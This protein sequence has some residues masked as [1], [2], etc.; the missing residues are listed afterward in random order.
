M[1]GLDRKNVDA[2]AIPVPGDEKAAPEPDT[3]SLDALLAS[4]NGSA[5]QF[6]TLWFSFLGLTLYF[7]IAALTATHQDLLLGEPKTL[8]AP[9]HSN[10]AASVLRDRAT[11]LFNLSLLPIDDAGAA[12]AHRARVRQAVADDHTG[13]NGARAQ[14]SL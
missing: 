7:A 14:F 4:L 13:R 3:K 5:E 6:Q 1:A 12:R 9:Q 8:P 11:A 2:S 10:P